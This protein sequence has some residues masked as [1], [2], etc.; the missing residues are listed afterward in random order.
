MIVCWKGS[1]PCKTRRLLR[2]LCRNRYPLRAIYMP[3]RRS[4]CLGLGS[5][6]RDAE[7]VP[8]PRGSSLQNHRPCHPRK[9]GASPACILQGTAWHQASHVQARWIR[10][11]TKW[12]TLPGKYFRSLRGQVASASCSSISGRSGPNWNFLCSSFSAEART[13]SKN[14]ASQLSHAAFHLS[15]SPMIS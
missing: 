14:L 12:H 9:L 13:G 15:H 4:V 6:R 8:T 2:I 10:R 11:G 7:V 3:R 1:K 5:K